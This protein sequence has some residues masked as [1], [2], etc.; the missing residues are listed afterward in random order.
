MMKIGNKNYK[1]NLWK[2]QKKKMCHSHRLILIEISFFF[3]T[4]SINFLKV[5]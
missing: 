5:S 3:L 2:K 4:L 1:E